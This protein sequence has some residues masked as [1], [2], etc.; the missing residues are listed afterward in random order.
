MLVLE[1]PWLINSFWRRES[2]PKSCGRSGLHEK[3]AG[4]ANTAPGGLPLHRPVS[5]ELGYGRR[6]IMKH[7]YHLTNPLLTLLCHR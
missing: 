5:I 1:D 2:M 7:K 3:S 6:L 4:L